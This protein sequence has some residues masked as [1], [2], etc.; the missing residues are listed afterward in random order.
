MARAGRAVDER[1]GRVV[2]DAVVE[3]AGDDEDLFGPGLV[4]VEFGQAA[5]GAMSTT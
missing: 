3:D 5:P 2:A 4:D 1:S